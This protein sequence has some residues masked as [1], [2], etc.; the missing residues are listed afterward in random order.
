MI[1]DA[2][3]AQNPDEILLDDEILS[4]S[5]TENAGDEGVEILRAIIR[6]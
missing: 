3:A 1:L 4:L 6:D 2:D 5:M